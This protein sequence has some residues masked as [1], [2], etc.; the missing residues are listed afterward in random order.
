MNIVKNA[1]AEDVGSGD[2]TAQLIGLETVAQA[3]VVSREAAI[4][5][6]IAWFN[7]VFEQ[8]NSEIKITWYAED[9]DQ[10][11]PNQ[12]LCDLEGSARDLLTGERTALNFLQLLSGTATMAHEYVKAARNAVVL[13]TRKTI[14]GLR[15]A[16]KY[17]VVCGGAKNHR[18]GLYDAF[19]I[20]ENHIFAAGSIENAVTAAQQLA[21]NLSVEVEVETL[22]ELKEALQAGADIVLLDNFSLVQLEEAVAIT[23]GKAKLEASGGVNLETIRAIA[24]T[25]V[26]FISVGAITKDVKAIDLSMRFLS[27]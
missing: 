4:L 22:D 12:K 17:A 5:C 1:L 10:I 24:N 6:G 9:G 21:A 16:Q 7:E 18:M 13:D 26:D 8:L 11:Q 25:G 2:L 3:Q 19:L 15:D 14:P 27:C 23:Q 20:K